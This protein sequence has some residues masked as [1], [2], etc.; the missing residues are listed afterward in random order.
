MRFHAVTS[1]FVSTALCGLPAFATNVSGD[2]SGIWTLAGSPYLLVGDVRVPQNLTLAI[3]PG[4]VV[5]A[6]GYYKISVEQGTLLAI[7]TADQ[8]ILMTADNHTTGWRG[9]R[10]VSA[11]N[12]TTVRHCVME[13]AKGTGSYPGVRGGAIFCQNCS[14]LIAHNELRFNYSH[15]SNLNGA[16]AGILT[17]TS[18]ATIEDN[19]IH[20]NQADSGGGVCITEYGTPQV[21]RNLITNN[22]AYNAG[23]GMYFGARSSPLVEQNFILHNWSGGWGGG[24]INS[25]TSFIYYGTY[26]TVRN[27]VIARNITPSGGDA[28]GGGG[29]YCRYDRAILTG[30][31]IADNE[32]GQGGG[33]YA[34]NYYAQ[35]PLVS[36]CVVWGNTAPS[37]AQIYLYAQSGGSGI[38]VSFSDVQGGWTGTENVD[39]DPLFVAPGSDDYHL[40]PGSPCIDRGDPAFVPAAGERD[41]DNQRRVWNGGSADVPRVDMG[42]DEYGSYAVGDLN[43][44]GVLDFGDI[45]P[46]VLA[47]SDPG[48]YQAAYPDCNRLNGDADGDGDVD[49]DDINPFVGI[50]SGT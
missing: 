2:Q 13:Y 17:E 45:N 30:N 4:V 37:G 1:L 50:L 8:P 19:Y 48:A 10:L 11:N 25:W 15:N 31:T 49:F 41:I 20:D 42:A 47:L 43:C 40:S 33:I 24:G 14:P 39:A 36:D 6:Q 16:G 5:N 34:L 35:S 12:A 27:N 32:A 29:V 28:A 22:T 23:G 46:F 18:D 26:A 38:E 9:L 3:E 21:R 44:D 7:G